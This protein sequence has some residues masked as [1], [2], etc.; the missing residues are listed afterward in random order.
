MRISLPWLLVLVANAASAQQFA[1]ETATRFPKPNPAEYSYA[2]AVGDIDGDGDLDL[3]FANGNGYGKKEEPAHQSRLFVNDGKGVFSDQS[4]ERLGLEPG[5][6]RDVDFGDIDG[7]GW[8]DLV[9]AGAFG[10]APQVLRNQAGGF[11]KNETATRFPKHDGWFGSSVAVGDVDMDG[12]LDLF[13]SCSGYDMFKPPGGQDRLY[14]NQGDGTYKDVTA[15]R[16]PPHLGRAAL[17]V[18]FADV[19]NDGDLDVLV[20]RRED[21]ASLYL[22]DGKGTYVD[23]TYLLAPDGTMSYEIQPGDLDGDGWLDLYLANGDPKGNTFDSVFKNAIK[24]AK[25]FEDLT[26]IWLKAPGANIKADDNEVELL[27]V[28]MDGDFDVLIAAIS[29]GEE[30]VLENDG[31]GVLS[32]I[33]NLVLGQGDATLDLEIGDFDGD[34]RPDLVTAQG[35]S[36]AFENKIYMSTGPKDTR[37][38]VFGPVTFHGP[39]AP[40]L[41]PFTVVARVLDAYTSDAG[42]RLK[43]V[44]LDIGTGPGPMGWAGGS[45]LRGVVDPGLVV[46]PVSLVLTAID[47]YGNVAKST[48]ASIVPKSPLDVFPDGVVDQKDLDLMVDHLTDKGGLKAEGDLNGDGKV[49][50]EDA[51]LLASGLGGFPVLSRVK[52]AKDNVLLVGANLGETPLVTSD[53]GIGATLIA[54]GAVSILIGGAGTKPPFTVTGAGGQ[55]SNALGVTP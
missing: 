15:L 32:P 12:D 53:G 51:Q 13:F 2:V 50:L 11:F 46:K 27:D 6:Y 4:L 9:F 55:L 40:Y 5:W 10:N 7:D 29:P 16:M 22:N 49:T 25:G 31:A 8:V 47:P 30:R 54:H 37:A 34:G 48:S 35:E 45:E 36:G 39:W 28:D 33:G 21:T 17:G 18:D 23:G 14:E 26:G 52:V 38:P 1:D 41:G 24:D 42:A 20:N 43:S 19:D 3:V 44:T